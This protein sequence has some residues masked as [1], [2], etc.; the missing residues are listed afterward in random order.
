M[1]KLCYPLPD[2]MGYVILTRQILDQLSFYKQNRFWKKESGGQLFV[3]FC[4]NIV[5]V[6]VATG[7]NKKDIRSR[8]RFRPHRQSEQA[9][10][11]YFFRKELHFFGDWHTH[12]QR[13]PEPSSS[14]I[15]SIAETVRNSEHKLPGCL[16]VVVGT[17]RFPS[18]LF[19]GF[20]NGRDFYELVP[21]Q[22]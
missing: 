13:T 1:T 7:P 16:L 18:G 20:H 19:V 8:Y 5:T 11:R 3:D 12:P 15:D 17:D 4:E 9:D 14:D 6:R 2:E 22:R 10:I 21:S